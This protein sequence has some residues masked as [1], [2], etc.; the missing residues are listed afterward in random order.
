MKRTTVKKHSV[1][2]AGL[3]TSVSL[4]DEFWKPLRHIA[5]DR[6]QTLSKLMADINGERQ[7]ANLSSAI[8]LF[9]LRYYQDQLDQRAGV[10]SSFEVQVL[11]SL[12]RRG[13]QRGLQR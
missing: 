9:V 10:V 2:V 4:E 3:K 1:V 11:N 8:R 6:S 5:W 12:E 13:T 7:T